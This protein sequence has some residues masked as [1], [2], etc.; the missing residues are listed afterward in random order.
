M[1][2]LYC[3]IN[4]K[5]KN[6][7]EKKNLNWIQQIQQITGNSAFIYGKQQIPCKWCENLHATECC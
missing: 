2:G 7:P 5:I 3:L 6:K 1:T 4:G